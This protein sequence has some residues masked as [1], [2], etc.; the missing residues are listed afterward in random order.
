MTTENNSENSSLQENET[1]NFEA[2]LLLKTMK[3]SKREQFLTSGQLKKILSSPVIE[4]KKL[5]SVLYPN[6]FR[7]NS[8]SFLQ[9]IDMI[10]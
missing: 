6:V 5:L 2:K 1:W 7:S 9:D 8:F 4:V 3:E 10:H